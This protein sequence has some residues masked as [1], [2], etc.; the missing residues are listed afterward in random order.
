MVN[1]PGDNSTYELYTLTQEGQEKPTFT[2]LE[3]KPKSGDKRM[4]VYYRNTIIENY[5]FGDL[6]KQLQTLVTQ[7]NAPE[8]K[9]A[10]TLESLVTKFKK[11][12]NFYKKKSE[13]ITNHLQ[14]ILAD[15][16]KKPDI[17]I[18]ERILKFAK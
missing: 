2:V 18:P 11:S 12:C 14:M 5:D 4:T 13:P 15:I 7:P 1:L 10:V 3:H 9:G 16:Q 6:R 8:V 17:N